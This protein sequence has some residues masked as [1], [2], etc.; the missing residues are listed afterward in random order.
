MPV[1]AAC[2]IGSVKVAALVHMMPPWHLA[3]AEVMLHTLLR[4]LVERGHEC[5]VV[6]RDAPE[7]WML[8]GVTIHPLRD[9][10]PRDLFDW[11]D[12]GVTHLDMTRPAI[13][14]A[15][16]TPL[17]HLVH[18]HVQLSTN[19]VTPRTCALAVFNSHWL[20][21]RVPWAGESTVI[22]PPVDCRDYATTPG[23]AVTLVN[24]QPAKGV[25]V[26]YRLADE[27]PDVD[28]LGVVGAYGDQVARRHLPNVLIHPTTGRMRNVYARTR[29]LLM[30]SHY[31]SFGRCAVEAACSGIPT[32]AAPTPGLQE[33]LGAAGTYARPDA[34]REWAE[35]LQRLL[36][37]PSA[38]EERSAAARARSAELADEDGVAAFDAALTRL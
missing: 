35:A 32:I 28:F 19:G 14:A 33:A 15:G 13:E 34:P 25:D 2:I 18:N 26:F 31:E 8:D 6:A 10:P 27:F 16:R 1:A 5:R 36:S 9:L 20:A 24:L 29:V 4:G 30:P 23:G 17:V 11:A 37:D 22:H 3:G 7:A 12:V 21:E 38:Y